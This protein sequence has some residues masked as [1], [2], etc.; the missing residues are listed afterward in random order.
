MPFLKGVICRFEHDSRIC[1]RQVARVWDCAGVV[2]N[3]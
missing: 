1:C 2:D 3:L